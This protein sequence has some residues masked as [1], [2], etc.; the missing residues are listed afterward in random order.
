[1]SQEASSSDARLGRLTICRCSPSTP[2]SVHTLLFSCVIQATGGPAHGNSPR[3]NPGC[4]RARTPAKSC[5]VGI[6][7]G[8]AQWRASRDYIQA[9]S[10][11]KHLRSR[12]C[13]RAIPTDAADQPLSQ[14]G[15]MGLALNDAQHRVLQWV[16][17]GADLVNPPHDVFKTSAVTCRPVARRSRSPSTRTTRP[18]RVI[19]YDR[20]VWAD[21]GF[22]ASI[23][24][25]PAILS[26]SF[27]STSLVALPPQ[28]RKAVGDRP[29]QEV[30]ARS[31]SRS[32]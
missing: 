20:P 31:V 17:D 27:V 19:G 22:A 21:I 10:A 29:W 30:T 26:S 24:D 25:L 28:V 11:Q 3:S 2:R 7:P 15:H 1:M 13:Q 32:L 4:F 16:A 23:L 18:L 6:P 9:C 12:G 8:S 5:P 14:T